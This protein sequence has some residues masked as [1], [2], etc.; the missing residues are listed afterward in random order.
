MRR[1]RVGER[2][3]GQHHHRIADQAVLIALLNL[4]KPP[5]QLR[6]AASVEQLKELDA[7]EVVVLPGVGA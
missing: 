2:L 1:V 7:I 6:I 5:L 3:K 4:G